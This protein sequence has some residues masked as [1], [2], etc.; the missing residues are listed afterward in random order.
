MCMDLQLMKTLFTSLVRPHSEYDNAVWHPQKKKDIQM[1]E[2]VQRTATKMVPAL[3]K[4]KY[5]ERFLKKELPS[6]M[7]RRAIGDD[8]K[9]YKHTRGLY[10]MDSGDLL[11]RNVNGPMVIQGHGLKLQKR[12]C[13]DK[14]ES[15]VLWCDSSGR[16]ECIARGGD[17]GRDSELFQATFGQ[18]LARWDVL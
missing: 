3:A 16:L 8:T 18:V 17:V 15:R 12:E 6:L 1:L 10:Q 4:L 14:S 5:A 7:Y 9:V 11:P 2:K 13:Q